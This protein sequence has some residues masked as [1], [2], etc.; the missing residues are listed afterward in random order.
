M[1]GKRHP[2]FPVNERQLLDAIAKGD[3]N[4]FRQLVEL[5]WSRVFGNSLA[6]LKSAATAQELTQD[7]FM[8]VWTQ[9]EK[10]ATVAH[11]KQYIYVVGRNLVLSSL[12]KKVI[13]TINEEGQDIVESVLL[14]DL[15]LEFKE[16]YKLVLDGVEALTPQQKLIFRMSRMEGLSHE[17]IAGK[18]RISKNTVKVHMVVALNFLRTY[19]KDHSEGL[20][21]IFFLVLQWRP[22]K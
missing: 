16:T 2:E 19:I 13:G 21:S 9:R 3:Q 4:A 1:V 7:I 5:Y 15:Q 6:L 10:L 11:F 17:E 12:R 14:P 20:L 8:K 22:G 18:L